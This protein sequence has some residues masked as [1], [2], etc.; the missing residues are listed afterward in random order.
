MRFLAFYLWKIYLRKMVFAGKF[1]K[2]QFF[3]IPTKW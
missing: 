2:I 3:G 1:D